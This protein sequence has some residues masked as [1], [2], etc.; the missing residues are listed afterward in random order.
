MGELFKF[1]RDP[2]FG[3]AI[4]I[5]IIAF[6]V[7]AT[8]FWNLH[9]RKKQEDSL[10][11]FSRLF[12]SVSVDEIARETLLKLGESLPALRFL[13][14]TYFRIGDYERSIKLYMAILECDLESSSRLNFLYSLGE[15][16]YYAGFLE[17]SKKILLEVLKNNPRNPE[18]L[19]LLM[20]SYEALGLY[21]EA[22]DALSCLQELGLPEKSERLN[23]GYLNLKKIFQQNQPQKKEIF[24]WL[25]SDSRLWTF[26]L[27]KLQALQRD[28]FWEAYLTQKRSEELLDLLWNLPKDELLSRA[29]QTNNLIL[30]DVC[31]AKGF[32]QIQNHCYIFELEVL[33]SLQILGGVKGDLEFSYRCEECKGS[34]PLRFER[35]LS[36][37]ALLS[38]ELTYKIRKVR[39][40]NGLSFL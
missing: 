16:Y 31:A 4:L 18:A 35:C 5:A 33:R 6:I 29:E 37:G 19:S 3:V 26:V 11:D 20:R 12:E 14:E 9:T 30:K 24:Y 17:R 1:F 10:K 13:A 21:D 39:D 36:C 40:E 25:E 2:L 15:V 8:Y 28:W 27:E 23:R 34:Y 32:M 22:L 38:G 7:L